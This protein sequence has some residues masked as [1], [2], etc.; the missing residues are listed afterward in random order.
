MTQYAVTLTHDPDALATL[1]PEWSTLLAKSIAANVYLTPEW[2]ATYWT[3]FGNGSELWLIVV[4]DAAGVLVGI[5]P[6][7][8]V[9][10]SPL[11][12]GPLRM[13]R[14][15]QIQFVGG[16]VNADHLDFI[17]APG[18]EA[19]VTG[20]MLDHL[21]ANR[22]RWDV[23]SFG[24]FP[25]NSPTFAVLHA[26]GVPWDLTGQ[27]ICPQIDLPSDWE[28]FFMS[29]SRRKRKEQRRFGRQLDE[30]FG[31]DW[32]WEEVTE[33]GAVRHT[34]DAL[35]AFHQAKWE[36]LEQA[37]GFHDPVVVAFHHA[38][39]RQF[40]ELG[41]L[42][43]LRLD[44][45]GELVAALYTLRYGDC[46]YDFASGFDFEYADYSPG[47]VLTEQSL[48]ACVESNVAVYDFL[49]GDEQYKFRWGASETVDVTLRWIASPQARLA[50]LGYRAVRWAWQNVKRVLPTN[51]RQQLR[52]QA[53][54]MD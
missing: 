2:L 6:L 28:T 9:W 16:I 7:Q 33:P 18:Q 26:R 27:M 42:R 21:W 31:D 37:G 41:R 8:L 39:A 15:R 30:A 47:Q 43:L 45:G 11:P 35:I 29:L 1:V 51:L 22:Y 49:R 23:L 32:C 4:R 50:Y 48:R 14:W 13:I 24:W 53:G 19:A 3:H 40:L 34:L 12:F 17:A 54:E 5:A 25:A 20:A 10:H 52:Q 44:I 46:V 38:V 36:S